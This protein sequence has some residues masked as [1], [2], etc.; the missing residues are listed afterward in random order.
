MDGKGVNTMSQVRKPT[1]EEVARRLQL[2]EQHLIKLKER[3][4]SEA[5][6]NPSQF[7]DGQVY[8]YQ[9]ASF[10]IS[11]VIRWMGGEL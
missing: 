1:L 7:S 8:A 3:N 6:E 11:R 5:L 10:L 4:K 9:M 2:F